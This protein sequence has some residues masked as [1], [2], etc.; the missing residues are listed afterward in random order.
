MLT[1]DGFPSFL[2]VVK[3]GLKPAGKDGQGHFRRVNCKVW[4]A[5]C[6]MY[7]GSGPAIKYVSSIHIQSFKTSRY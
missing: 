6:E 4:E 7:K 3:K 1:E 2:W 5:F